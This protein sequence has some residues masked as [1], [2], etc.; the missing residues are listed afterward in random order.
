MRRVRGAAA[1]RR[2]VS[3][4]VPSIPP[5]ESPAV[6]FV[7][8]FASLVH[9]LE[10]E[11]LEADE[12]DASDDGWVE[13]RFAVR[14]CDL[15]GGNWVLPPFEALRAAGHRVFLSSHVV[16]GQINV[17]AACGPRRQASCS[18]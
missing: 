15:W 13:N 4:V 6:C 9:A 5:G 2:G 12:C 10:T 16:P 14:F 8:P 11:P 7:H 1:L 3:D 18:W 17:R